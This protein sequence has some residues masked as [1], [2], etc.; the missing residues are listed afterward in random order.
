[1]KQNSSNNLSTV[2]KSLGVAA[3][4]ATIVGC[5]ISSPKPAWVEPRFKSIFNG[6]SLDGWVLMG[7]QG[8]GLVSRTARSFVP[9]VAAEIS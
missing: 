3:I 4:I 7:K 8:A 9:E 1:M 5:A 6:E 2:A